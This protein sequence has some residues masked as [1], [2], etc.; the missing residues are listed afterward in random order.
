MGSATFAALVFFITATLSLSVIMLQRS[1]SH[2]NSP[3]WLEERRTIEIFQR[4]APSVVHVTTLGVDQSPLPTLRADEDPGLGVGSGF[5]WN[6]RGYIVTSQHVVDHRGEVNVTLSDGSTHKADLVGWN[7]ATDLAVIA[8][9]VPS[10]LLAPL[11]LGSSADL[12]VGQKVFSISTPFGLDQTLTVGVV[13]ALNRGIQALNGKLIRGVVQTDAAINPGSSGGPLLDSSGAVIGI[14]TA[15][16]DSSAT[17][18]GVGF[19]VPVD[20]IR[21]IVPH[22]I[23]SGYEPWPELG[24]VLAPTDFSR[25]F[26]ERMP[27][28]EGRNGILVIEVKVDSPAGKAN[29]VP[30]VTGDNFVTVGDAIIGIDG[31]PVV[32]RDVLSEVLLKKREG[33]EVLLKLIR[34]GLTVYETLVF[35]SR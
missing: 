26:L 28:E 25:H 31:R 13:S 32:S 7:A 33:D 23:Q 15:I 10:G 6:D 30:V 16:H 19:A 2:D 14:T 21:R 29:I 18:V 8:I 9:A 5:V 35:G 27:T 22:I 34:G 20:T 4:V 3:L 24:L 11:E 1:R 12:Q 17:N